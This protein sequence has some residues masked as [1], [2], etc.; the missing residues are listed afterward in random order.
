MAQGHQTMKMYYSTSISTSRLIGCNNV[1]K[2][3]K[4][5]KK[6]WMN[7]MRNGFLIH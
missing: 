2:E 6:D 7:I 5:I 4:D 1:K 3:K